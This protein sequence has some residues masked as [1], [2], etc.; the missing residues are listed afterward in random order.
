MGRP[1]PAIHPPSRRRRRLYALAGRLFIVRVEHPFL[2]NECQTIGCI[3]NFDFT[4]ICKLFSKY[5]ISNQT[6]HS[7]NNF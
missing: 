1:L 3:E 7:K 6:I 4:I 2:A 5:I